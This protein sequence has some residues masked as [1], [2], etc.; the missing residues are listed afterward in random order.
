MN[1]FKNCSCANWKSQ[2]ADAEYQIIVK[3]QKKKIANINYKIMT[4]K[5]K[6]N[7]KRI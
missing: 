5:N 1:K 6:R 7:T 2:N 3:S 4:E